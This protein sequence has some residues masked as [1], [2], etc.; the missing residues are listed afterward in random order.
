[1]NDPAPFTRQSSTQLRTVGQGRQKGALPGSTLTLV[2]DAGLPG[3][4]RR[5]FQLTG[6]YGNFVKW[7][8]TTAKMQVD[9]YSS[10]GAL[11]ATVPG[12]TP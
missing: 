7:L 2:A 6:S 11:V 1:M 5:E 9:V 3:E 8:A 4:E 10:G 12:A